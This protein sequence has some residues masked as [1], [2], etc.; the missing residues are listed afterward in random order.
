MASASR[1]PEVD[2][3]GGPRCAVARLA[4]RC[5]LKTGVFD[6]ADQERECFVLAREA[7]HPG[8]SDPMGKVTGKVSL[9][10]PAGRGLRR[11]K[12]LIPLVRLA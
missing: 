4:V 9:E 10:T 12:L 6:S 1:G 2:I 3:V 8:F 5:V 11:A 7:L